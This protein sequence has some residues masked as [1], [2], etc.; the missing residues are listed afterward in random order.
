MSSLFAKIE[1]EILSFWEKNQIFQK[2]L[3]KRK[4]AKEFI[5]YEGPPTANARPGLH[6][7]L[8]RAFKDIVCRYKTMRGFKVERRAGWDTHGL[9]V[10]IQVEQKLGL[11]TK[12]GIEEYGIAAFNQECKKTVF[13]HIQEFEDLTRKIGYW[14]DFKNSYITYT[15]E[16]IESVWFILKELWNKKL[17]YQDF[18]V[19]PWCYR[20]GTALSSHEVAQGYKS[21]QETS[22]YVKFNLLDLQKFGNFPIKEGKI[23]LLSWTT[24][25]WTLPGNVALAVNE[26]IEYA[27]VRVKNSAGLFENY[28][29]AKSR[30][31]KILEGLSFEILSN[32]KGK[33]LGGLSYEPLFNIKEFT[34]SQS[35]KVYQADF[36]SEE[37]GTGI[38]HIAPMYGV[39]DFELGKKVSLPRIHTVNP[40][41]TFNKLVPQF[42]G[43]LVKDPA[44]EEK[45][46]S[47]LRERDSFLKAE[48]LTHD[49]PF[50]WRCK[51]PLLYFAKD[52]WFIAVS[53]IK[54]KLLANNEKINWIPAHLKEGRFGSWLKEVKDW[55]LSRERYWGTP[56]PL[57]RCLNCNQILAIGSFQELKRQKFTTNQYYFLRHLETSYQAEKS[58]HLYPPFEKDE[59]LLSEKGREKAKELAQKLKKEKIDLIFS[60][61]LPRTRE[62]AKIIG[63]FLQKEV[64]LDQRLRDINFGNYFGSKKEDFLKRYPHFSHYLTTPI[65]GGESFLDCAQRFF[66]FFKEIEK[67]YRHQKILI[68]SH[69]GP[70]MILL[71]MMEGAPLKELK[72][73]NL[74][75]LGELRKVDFKILPYNEEAE[76]DL[77]R[78]YIDEV[79]FL[80]PK[81]GQQMERFREVIDVWFDSGAMP[82]AQNHFPFELVKNFREKINYQALVKKI[83]FPADYI[84]EAID[85]TRGWFYTLLAVATLLDL[86]APYKNVISLGHVLDEKGEKMSKSKGNVIDPWQTIEEFSADSLRWYFFTINQ[87]EDP[88]LFSFKDLKNVYQ[89]FLMTLWNSFLFYK[90]YVPQKFRFS[91]LQK[92]FSSKNVLD[93]WLLSRLSE[94]ILETTKLLENYEITKA[95]RL[96]ENFV[97]EDLSQWYIRRSRRR[98]QK[99]E[100]REDFQKAS[101][102]L[103]FCLFNLTLLCAPF[104]PFLSEKIYQELKKAKDPLS[105]HLANWPSF[106]KRFLKPKLNQEMLKARLLVKEGLN[107]R[108][109]AGIKVRQPLLE[110]R[111]RKSKD[112]QLKKE[113]IEIIKDELNV[114]N[115]VFDPHL[116]EKVWLNTEITKELRFEGYLREMIRQIQMKRKEMNLKPAEKI[117]LKIAF[118]GEFNSFLKEKLKFLK[119]EVNAQEIFLLKVPL[120]NFEKLK[121]GDQESIFFL[122]LRQ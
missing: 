95:A 19:V 66:D 96:I 103:S 9:P 122:V 118:Q 13:S 4:R 86:G 80:C 72:P 20:C 111:V 65:E 14:L 62:T 93:Q 98:F 30:I 70:L 36:V 27:L 56:L 57:W 2:S 64:I 69:G 44:T 43:L 83:P 46:I 38:V 78:P 77:H 60:S 113:I 16:Y 22:I 48:K 106:N 114:K 112:F 110:I 116:K 37:E 90:T 28:I 10:E 79:K 115:F 26:K 1:S 24:T 12:K 71:A 84:A 5:F 33:E 74:F 117:I 23:Y 7:V 92:Y 82:F 31:P 119:K 50:C 17:L 63:D 51:N 104:I 29:L 45:I 89:G 100:N 41:G 68:V 8:A 101:Q 58:E 107:Q 21:I 47:F 91:R 39:E 49:Y 15:K 55:A 109:K 81:C 52:S 76:I 88:K 121:L 105:V 99:P 108:M 3:L 32:F 102:T 42:E 34:S 6:H 11:K 59:V 67:K 120:A 25:P 97:I 94:L 75:K 85:Q 18:K 54:K 87:P 40:E 73:T 61:D 53:K 35:Y